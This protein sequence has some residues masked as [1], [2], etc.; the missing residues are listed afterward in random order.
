M[1]LMQ[2]RGRGRLASNSTGDVMRSVSGTWGISTRARAWRSFPLWP[3]RCQTSTFMSSGGNAKDVERWK[4]ITGPPAN[5]I[6]HGHVSP[7][8]A[9]G[10]RLA[11]DVLI[12]PYQQE[13]HNAGGSQD[14]ARWMSPLKIFEYMAAGKP[15]IAS[16]LPVLR[17]VLQHNRQALLVP[18][19]DVDGWQ[20]A[21]R[22]LSDP[23][24]RG[25]L[26]E[27]ALRTFQQSHTWKQRANLVLHGLELPQLS[28]PQS[29]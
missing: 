26:G 10:Y 9:D 4:A 28:L 3:A 29:A 15:I 13:V 21:V 19:A 17:E 11:M 22:R 16:D 24:L 20:Q 25:Q 8:E 14:I 1:Q 2:L 6:F 7:A 12:A 5:L 23:R 18:P 27:Q